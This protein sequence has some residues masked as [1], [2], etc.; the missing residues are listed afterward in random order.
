MRLF[1]ALDLPEAVTEALAGVELDDAVWRRVRDLH[2]TL[3]FLGEREDPAPYRAVVEREA[4]TPA[5][6]LRLGRFVVLRTALAV[7]L[8]HEGLAELQARIASGCNAV[9]A[10]AFRAHVT[11]ARLRP[12]VRRPRSF[13]APLEPL[14]FH[15]PSVTLYRSRLSP[16]GA[17][18][19]PLA[20][21]T[22]R[23]IW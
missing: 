16:K 9:E 2:V 18:Y 14:A 5:P 20:S 12:R 6:A 3:A 23:P 17:A 13:R 1:V 10:R 4:G 22:L 19:E 8:E 21:A 7:E 15:A 11:I